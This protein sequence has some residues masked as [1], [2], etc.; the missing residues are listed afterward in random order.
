MGG[1][2]KKDRRRRRSLGGKEKEG[3]MWEGS[4]EGEREGTEVGSR[5][6]GGEGVK[7]GEE[8]CGRWGDREID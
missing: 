7:R 6:R 2:R 3:P 8:S 4:R 1:G 5:Q